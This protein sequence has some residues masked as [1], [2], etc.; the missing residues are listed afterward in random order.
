MTESKT[1]SRTRTT[2][3]ATGKTTART[4]PAKISE[5]KY[6]DK[7][8]S[9]SM[10]EKKTVNAIL[11]DAREQTKY[12]IAYCAEHLRIRRVHLQAIEDAQYKELPT[13]AHG[14]GFVRS[15]A[16][17]L[18]LPADKIVE[19]YR[20]ETRSFSDQ[21]QLLMPVPLNDNRMPNWRIIAACVGF[22]LFIV[23]GWNVFSGPSQPVSTVEK[24]ET[25]NNFSGSPDETASSATINPLDPQAGLLP[26]AS[27]NQTTLPSTPVPTPSVALPVAAGQTYGETTKSR[28]ELYATQDSWIQIRDI[29]NTPIFSKVLHAGDVYNAPAQSGLLL[30]VGNA[31][32]LQIR[33]DGKPLPTL[34]NTGQIL[35]GISLDAESL[36]NKSPAQE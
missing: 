18:G 11:K 33:I 20:R 32:G 31:G 13:A 8:P 10:N 22:L 26:A 19:Q 14:V 35:K 25:D 12:S 21:T 2:S 24:L 27:P 34:G 30:T 9:I 16:D 23:I 29:N 5:N 3:S 15:Y 4:S 6:I 28:I 36:I 7:K 1:T 17:F